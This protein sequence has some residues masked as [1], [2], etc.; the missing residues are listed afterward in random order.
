MANQQISKL[1]IEN[2]LLK[3]M[4]REPSITAYNRLEPRPRSQDF[5]R[6]L[7]AEIR[8]P[9]WMITRQW[10]MGEFEAED[11]GSAIDARLLTRQTKVDRISLDHENGKNYSDDIP[12]ETFVERES[13]VFGNNDLG[14]TY[15]LRVKMGQYFLKLHTDALRSKYISKYLEKYGFDVGKED[16]FKGQIDGLNLYVA[17]KRRVI[18]GAKIYKDI[19]D[20]TIS[21]KI[22]IEAGDLSEMKVFFNLYQEWFLRQYSQPTE[23][24]NK[25]WH[26]KTLDYQF[27]VAA[28]Y[29]NGDQKVLEASEYYSGR[30]DWYAFSENLRSDGL[31]TDNSVVA[32]DKKVI[33][34]FLP[35]PAEFKGMPN[36]RFWEME[37]RQI[38][39]GKINAK[40]TDHL[41]LLFAEFGLI[42]GN[43]WSVIPYNMS[44]NTICEV[45]GLVVTD[46]FG[47][48]T[49]IR[50]A[51]EGDESDWQR[52]SMFN[53]SN[54]D[55]IGLYNRQFFLP[56]TLI[57]SLQSD[58][59][60]QVNFMRDEMAN[61]VWA[62]EETIPDATG[63]GINGNEASD[64]TGVLPPPIANSTAA[65]R[66][67][68]GTSVPENWIPFLPVQKQNAVWD[69]R[70]QRASMPKLGEPPL[71]VV[72]AK[73]LLLNEVAAPYYINEE[74]IPYSGSI[75]KRTIQRVRWYDGKTYV[76][77]GRMRETGRGQGGSNLRFDQIE[78]L[79]GGDPKDRP[80]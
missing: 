8:D 14:V 71:E 30:L 19:E 48:R 38:D 21:T 58:P 65:I 24:G 75:V 61:M 51:N 32:E 74:E 31:K 60:E 52:W 27:S 80:Q 64:Q 79:T 18:D 56:S 25:A 10:Q 47:D 11:A 62:I 43:D 33:L 13:I 3:A 26:P 34:S 17:T 55:D 20:D 50:A 78:P 12:M 63:K 15:G 16:I 35:S 39:F 67:L 46:V 44:V 9:L 23:K 66:Y 72:N 7:R 45:K 70:F 22:G 37:E 49:L 28:P 2:K 76:W 41:L 68:L 42:Y 29:K 57:H 4:Y 36:P 40:T 59:I 53:I 73:G 1:L 6:S 77:T 69:I 5:E 54:K